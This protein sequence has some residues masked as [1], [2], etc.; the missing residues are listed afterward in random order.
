MSPSIDTAQSQWLAQLAS[1][2]EAIAELD[3]DKPYSNGTSYGDDLL[4]DNDDLTGGS[5]SDD[6][7]DISDEDYDE[8]SSDY[9][10]ETLGD[11]D[12]ANVNGTG[13]GIEWLKSRTCSLANQRSGLEANDLQE[14]IVALLASDSSGECNRK[15]GSGLIDRMY[16]R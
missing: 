11:P 15:F 12:K 1:M 13:R 16:R 2:R 4:L 5:G 7:F 10:E 6:I 8:E 3:L 14:Q 9:T